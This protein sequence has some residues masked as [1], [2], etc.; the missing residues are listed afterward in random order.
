MGGWV[1]LVWVFLSDTV[2]Y[3]ENVSVIATFCC[4][5]GNNFGG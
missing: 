2:V 5:K 1:L 3:V 4:I